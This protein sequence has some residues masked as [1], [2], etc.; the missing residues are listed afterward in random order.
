MIDFLTQTKYHVASDSQAFIARIIMHG[1]ISD[2]LSENTSVVELLL[3]YVLLSLAYLKKGGTH[4]DRDRV[5]KNG[6]R[7]F[8]VA[9]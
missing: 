4:V 3:R 9:N 7:I 1:A 2:R 6:R 5:C 8:P